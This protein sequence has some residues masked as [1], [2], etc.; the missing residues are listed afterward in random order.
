M[1]KPRTW[2][3]RALV[4]LRWP[5]GHFGC[6]WPL[7]GPAAPYTRPSWDHIRGLACVWH[8]FATEWYPETTSARTVIQERLSFVWHR[9]KLQA[10]FVQ[11]R[12][13]WWELQSELCCKVGFFADFFRDLIL[14]II[15]TVCAVWGWSSNQSN[16][17]SNSHFCVGAFVFTLRYN[18]VYF[19]TETWATLT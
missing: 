2:R 9:Y 1:T 10:V 15:W 11:R 3:R 14:L 5:P 4:T 12:S 18:T 16:T 19:V 13:I 17:F 8:P 6:L 7:S